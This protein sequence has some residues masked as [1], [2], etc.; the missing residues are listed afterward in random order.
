MFNID[1]AL[2][3]VFD[4]LG[5]KTWPHRDWLSQTT[6]FGG[7]R[8][9]CMPTKNVFLDRARAPTSWMHDP[10]L[11]HTTGIPA[12]FSQLGNVFNAQILNHGI[13]FYFLKK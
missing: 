4:Y 7:L 11:S 3:V 5:L 12:L 10:P 1:L 9:L 13:L 2:D 8:G 6:P